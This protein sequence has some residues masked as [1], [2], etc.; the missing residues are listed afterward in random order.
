[1]GVGKIMPLKIL[2]LK[3]SDTETP[4]HRMISIILVFLNGYDSLTFIGCAS[5]LLRCPVGHAL[6]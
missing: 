6:Q 2:I 1:L 4:L 5:Y 3:P